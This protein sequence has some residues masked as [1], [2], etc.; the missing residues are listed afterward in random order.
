MTAQPQVQFLAAAVPPPMQAAID[1]AVTKAA[2]PKGAWGCAHVYNGIPVICVDHPK[3]GLHCLDC[4]A[5]HEACCHGDGIRDR[6]IVCGEQPTPTVHHLGAK[7]VA[8]TLRA[9]TGE[10]AEWDGVVLVGILGVCPKCSET[11]LAGGEA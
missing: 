3:S 4:I 5:E 6:C 7:S 2:Q 1:A 11:L 9:P 10:T 8:M